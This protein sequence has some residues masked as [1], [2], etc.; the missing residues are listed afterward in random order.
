MSRIGK[1]PVSLPQGVQAKIENKTVTISGEKGSLSHVI[2]PGIT[3]ES[4]GDTLV[5][6]RDSEQKTV[7]SLHG[8]TRALIHNMVVGVSQGYERTLIVEG[9][10]YKAKAEKLGVVFD[11]GYSHP[12]LFIPP[13][14]VSLNVVNPT[15]VTVSGIDK[16]LVG[17]VAA[18]I[19]S[20]RAPAVY[21][22][23]GIRYKDEQV[24]RKAGK[25]GA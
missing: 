5:V 6:Q 22:G 7:R 23:K 14:G 11:V 4:H 8:L 10:G 16:Q 13:D 17:Q 12:I 1:M 21:T 20:F 3:V 9:V 24:R 15:E 19:R 18:K 25:G 2:P